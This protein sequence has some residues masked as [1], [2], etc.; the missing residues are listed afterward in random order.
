M[1]I[2]FDAASNS[3]AQT[4]ATAYNWSHTCTGSHLML[5]VA[6]NQRTTAGNLVSGVTYN[7]IKLNQAVAINNGT[8]R[9]DLWYLA[10]PPT[11]SHS[12]AVTLSAAPTTSVAEA[13]S[14]TGVSRLDAV[15][16]ASGTSTTPSVAVTTIADNCWV[17]DAMEAGATTVPS[18]GGSQ[19]NVTSVDQTNS[20]W[21]SI[22]TQGPKTPAGSVTMSW[23]IS[24]SVAWAQVACSFKP[25]LSTEINLLSGTVITII[26]PSTTSAAVDTTGATLL[27]VAVSKSGVGN[28]ASGAAISDSQ[29]NTW[30]AGSDVSN[31]ALN[32]CIWYAYNKGAGALSTSA[33]HTFTIGSPN[34]SGA[35][36]CA[37]SGTLVSSTPLD[38]QN[39]NTAAT[40]TTVTTG[41]ITPGQNNEL[42]IAII[43]AQVASTAPFSINNIYNMN[44]YI[45]GVAGNVQAI[46]MA[47]LIQ[48][49][50]AATNPTFTVTIASNLAA[51][52][53]SFKQAVVASVPIAVLMMDYRR[54]RI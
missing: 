51:A 16:S 49:T 26:G 52:I 50:A 39:T 48:V 22:S 3:G 44:E 7:G 35:V 29:G 9:A 28:V 36:C 34:T 24:A 4:T 31:S 53:A 54:R 18:A 37:F 43:D 19:A 38:Q 25:Y 23:T 41:S 11:G 32:A 5:V 46:G 40:A 10:N 15:N 1:S 2:T 47:Y 17:I 42:V 21:G 8:R 6:I 33:S 13:I 45:P 27:I 14:L 12:I 30:Q 20:F